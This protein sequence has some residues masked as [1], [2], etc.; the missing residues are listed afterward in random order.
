MTE[1][2][3][4]S[5]YC[6][7]SFHSLPA[8]CKGSECAWW[9]WT[10]NVMPG[11]FVCSDPMATIEPPRPRHIPATWGWNPYDADE[12]EPAAWLQ[13]LDEA[14]REQPGRCGGIHA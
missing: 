12:G 5:K 10:T 1:E 9:V 6:P 3:A 14:K 13:P 11:V 8:R 7:L 2:E 4:K